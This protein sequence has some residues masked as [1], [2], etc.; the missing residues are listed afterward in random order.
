MGTSA[1]RRAPTT[2]LWRMAKGA[3]T[4][5][6]SPE[7][8][9]RVEA[10][11]VVARYLAALQE[12]GSQEDK[13]GLAAFRLTRKVAQDLGAFWSQAASQ[14]WAGA[15]TAL[16][17]GELTGQ[18]P[19]ILAQGLGAALVASSGGLEAEVAR[20]SLAAVL[21]RHLS[22]ASNL[23]PLPSPLPEPFQ[24]V[25]Q[26]LAVALYLR[27][28]L[29]L[30]ESLEAAAPSFKRLKIGLEGIKGWIDKAAGSAVLGEP[31]VPNQW[32][33]LAGWLW[34]TQVM[35]GLVQQLEQE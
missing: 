35:A 20:V 24:L 16:G 8:V 5:Y 12:T 13:R 1:G 27:L 6:L 30:G 34:V 28:S 19:E 32:P 9:G 26:F 10:R 17:L 18:S 14:G 29:D 21:C 15:L 11:E 33:G 7:V 31:P 23:E 2:R 4:R 25:R 3:A 22:L